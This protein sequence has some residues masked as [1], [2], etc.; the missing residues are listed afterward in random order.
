MLLARAL[1]YSFARQRARHVDDMFAS[2]EALRAASLC[3]LMLLPTLFCAALHSAPVILMI[4]FFA[5][6]A[7]RHD[8][9]AFSPDR[10][11]ADYALECSDVAADTAGAM[12]VQDCACYAAISRRA[13]LCCRRH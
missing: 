1:P 8:A 3:L 11:H 12:R 4:C 9:D 6:F 7:L 10:H 13:M 2:A 5:I